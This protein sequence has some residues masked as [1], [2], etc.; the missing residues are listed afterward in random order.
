MFTDIAVMLYFVE[1]RGSVLFRPYG[2]HFRVPESDDIL[3]W[4]AC[5]K[6]GGI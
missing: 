5:K 4:N 3:C 6:D 2:Y 1:N